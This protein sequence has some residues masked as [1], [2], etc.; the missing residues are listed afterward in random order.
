LEQNE[1]EWK[2]VFDDAEPQVAKFP[3][4]WSEKLS[5]FQNML[6]IRCLWPDKVV[7]A[8]QNFVQSTINLFIIYD[9]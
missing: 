2:T 1:E 8:V 3:A 9:Y 5:E 7:P 4:P 6:V